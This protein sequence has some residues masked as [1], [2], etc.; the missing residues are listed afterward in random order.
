M[1]DAQDRDETQYLA[2]LDDLVERGRTRAEMLLERFHGPW[3]GSVDP[4]F[5]ECAY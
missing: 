5:T 1:L 3:R 2:P 4:V